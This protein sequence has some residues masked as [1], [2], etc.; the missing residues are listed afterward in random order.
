ML[1]YLRLECLLQEPNMAVFYIYVVVCLV[2]LLD[3]YGL[4]MNTGTF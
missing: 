3:D 4:F 1:S 2:C